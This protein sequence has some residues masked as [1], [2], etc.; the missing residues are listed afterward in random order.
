MKTIMTNI[1]VGDGGVGKDAK[2]WAIKQTAAIMIEYATLTDMQKVWDNTW[3]DIV[4]YE[5]QQ[6]AQTATLYGT[7]AINYNDDDDSNKYV[8]QQNGWCVTRPGVVYMQ[9]SWGGASDNGG[10]SELTRRRLNKRS[11]K[12]R[13]GQNVVVETICVRQKRKPSMLLDCG[14]C[15]KMTLLT[16]E[17]MLETKKEKSWQNVARCV[18]KK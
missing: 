6:S 13:L 15:N 14:K 4:R 9:R 1:K 8:T 5:T 12:Q 11:Q 2:T 18:E 10:V 7:L 16:A 17:I 3:L